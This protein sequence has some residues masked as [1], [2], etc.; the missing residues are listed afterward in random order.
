MADKV[1]SQQQSA[2]V[3]EQVNKT[4]KKTIFLVSIP[5][6]IL[7]II[8]AYLLVLDL[9]SKAGAGN[10]QAH[11]QGQKAKQQTMEKATADEYKITET[12]FV[13]T[14]PEFLFVVKDLIV[15][16]AG[17]GVMRY[18]LTSVGIEVTNEKVFAEIQT[19]EVIV[20]DILINVLSSKTLE[21]LTDVTKRKELRREIANKINEILTQGRVQNVYFSKFIVQ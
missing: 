21:E 5:I 3:S 10:S 12:E 18:L 4:S 11:T 19:K 9:N 20:N 7:Q 13:S 2:V 8:I 15:N 6:V 14:H 1:L 17:T 16:P